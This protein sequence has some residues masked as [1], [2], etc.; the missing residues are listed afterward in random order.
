M[1]CSKV[2]QS[3]R[4]IKKCSCCVRATG[5]RWRRGSCAK[6]TTPAL[7]ILRF[8]LESILRRISTTQQRHPAVMLRDS[9]V[10]SIFICVM[11]IIS[12]QRENRFG[13]VFSA[14][15][16]FCKRRA[17]CRFPVSGFRY[18]WMPMCRRLLL[19]VRLKLSGG[20]S[21]LFFYFR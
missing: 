18:I 15:A 7:Q 17:A 16:R 6:G 13:G 3:T 2:L 11:C 5:G 1:N 10:K 12:N 21:R 19:S 8:S 9:R 4:L 20:L 14:M